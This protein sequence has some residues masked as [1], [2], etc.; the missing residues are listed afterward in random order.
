MT[1]ERAYNGRII[2]VQPDA[3]HA[4]PGLSSSIAT[5]VVSRSPLHGWSQHGAYGARS[6]TPTKYMD[7]GSIVHALVLGKG[8]DIA[9]LDF[10]SYKTNAAKAARDEARAL[11]RTP[12]LSEDY[13]EALMLS[14][15]IKSKLEA[16]GL[17]L[18]GQSEVAIEWTEDSDYG[19]VPCRGMLDHV[20]LDT[21]R[22]VDLKVV[23]N[24]APS[25]VER[26]SEDYGYAIQAC[27]YQR[28]L[29][30]LDPSLAGRTEFIFAFCEPEEP[31]AIN[32]SR[33]CGA[34]EHIG[35][36]RWL[37]A[38]N[39]WGKCI[40]D[41]HWPAYGDDINFVSPPQWALARDAQEDELTP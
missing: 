38:V 12:I 19:P 26:S 13:G 20:F 40:R 5:T 39:A 11:N 18:N 2:D 17:I 10:D 24:A 35:E 27:A 9:V 21:G 41:N 30:A 31:F 22:I 3:Y 14:V 29:R 23:T 33:P 25:K 6:R 16:R 15:V 8:K 4:L 28:A 7:R 32:L 34:F 37:R 36:R 1:T